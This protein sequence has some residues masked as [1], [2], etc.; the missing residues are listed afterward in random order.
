VPRRVQRPPFPDTPGK[1]L[2]CYR[3]RWQ[4][5]G[6]VSSPEQLGMALGVSGTTVRRWE[7]GQLRP[8]R[9]DISRV[10]ATCELT[11]LEEVFLLD[12]FQNRA[13]E[14]PPSE[15]AFAAMAERALTSENPAFLM[16][17][18]FFIRARNSYMKA[19]TARDL[20]PMTSNAMM[21]VFG[22]TRVPTLNRSPLHIVRSFWFVTAG[23]SGLPPFRRLLASLREAEGFEDTWWR[24]ALTR[25][26]ADEAHNL[27]VTFSHPEHGVYRVYMTRVTVPPVY[28]LREYVPV[29]ETA[30]AFVK[31]LRAAGANTIEGGDPHHWA[32]Q[33]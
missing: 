33:E 13:A 2:A 9:E 1:W 7:A 16:D 32:L 26:E 28:F 11:P 25:E 12:A 31:G 18:L 27:P 22:P 24:L 20:T 14:Q 29:D 21:G 17:S 5:D 19:L 10:A 15:E 30:M 6:K 4:P 3:Y 23:L 8:T